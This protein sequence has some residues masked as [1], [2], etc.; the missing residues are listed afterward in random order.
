MGGIPPKCSTLKVANSLLFRW[1]CS[2][3]CGGLTGGRLCSPW[4]SVA[5]RYGMWTLVFTLPIPLIVFYLMCRL[6]LP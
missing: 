4:C 5:E 2:F 3:I 1:W 6:L